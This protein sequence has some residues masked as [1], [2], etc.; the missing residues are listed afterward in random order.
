MTNSALMIA[1]AGT[2]RFTP[3]VAPPTSPVLVQQAVSLGTATAGSINITLA[4]APVA[5]NTLVMFVAGSDAN[6][7]P[8]PAGWTLVSNT[9]AGATT[10]RR[11]VYKRIADGT[12]GT[13]IASPDFA[14]GNSG[15]SVQEWQGSVTITPAEGGQTTAGTGSFTA[16]PFAAPAA[17][18]VPSVFGMFNGSS[19]MPPV[20][21]P[22]GWTSA[23]PLAN[24][25]FPARGQV[26]A[27]GPA[28]SGAVPAQTFT[29]TGTRG[30]GVVVLWVGAWIS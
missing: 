16:G 19:A 4:S 7:R 12:E 15:F 13:T 30:N 11:A 3:V 6:A 26:V 18:A 14:V 24:G 25:S 10:G 21:P 20:T 23:G 5:G 27:Y 2:L 29:Y 17:T 8:V 22:T 9:F 1:I 28:T